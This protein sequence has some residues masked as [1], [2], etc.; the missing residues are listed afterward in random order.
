MLGHEVVKFTDNTKTA[1]AYDFRYGVDVR[2]KSEGIWS[3]FL[4]AY[5]VKS[6]RAARER[7]FLLTTE[8]NYMRWKC[9]T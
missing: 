4:L 6:L 2:K 1:I 8:K 9:K 5:T 7:P 3:F